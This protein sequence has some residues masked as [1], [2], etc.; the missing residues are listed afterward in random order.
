MKASDAN[1]FVSPFNPP[2]VM[3][4]RALFVLQFF[5][6][7]GGVICVAASIAG[8]SGRLLF[9]GGLCFA[10]MLSVQ[11]FLR[12]SGQWRVCVD[13]FNQSYTRLDPLPDHEDGSM[14]LMALLDRRDE[15]ENSR[16][17]PGFDPWALQEIRCE[18]A[19]LLKANP[20]LESLLEEL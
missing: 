18:I 4:S 15:M 17:Q 2:A 7:I 3:R 19:V 5:A 6:L 11:W 13:G 10:L 20:A 12:R 16:S 1:P 9:F 8:E 14:Q